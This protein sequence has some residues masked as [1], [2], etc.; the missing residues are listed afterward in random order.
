MATSSPFTVTVNLN[1]ETMSVDI[2]QYRKVSD[3]DNEVLGTRSYLA[4]DLPDDSTANCLLYGISKKVQDST[5]AE[6]KS[7]GRLGSMDEV[8]D[9]LKNSQWEKPREGG[10]PT[11]S[12]EVEALA[13]IKGVEVAVIQKTLR[14][15]APEQRE[16]VLAHPTVV[17]K[18]AEIK[19]ARESAGSVDFGDLMSEDA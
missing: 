12:A 6:S 4:A 10:G 15:L 17:A 1:I 8:L 13:Q 19:E 16:K 5:S 3:G 9:R 18:A 11:V 14:D 7:E 2:T